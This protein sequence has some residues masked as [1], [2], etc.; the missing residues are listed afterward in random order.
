MELITDYFLWFTSLTF[1]KTMVESVKSNY[2][3]TNFNSQLV[4][5]SEVLEV[6]KKP[7]ETCEILGKKE[8]T[9][10]G[11]LDPN[12]PGLGHYVMY[13]GGDICT[14]GDNPALNGKPRQT[15]FKIYCASSQDEN[16]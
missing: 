6:L 12:N 9:T 13:G 8:V 14:N 2:I 15:K 16:V 3:I 7:T 1:V 10:N 4:S 5:V 11:L